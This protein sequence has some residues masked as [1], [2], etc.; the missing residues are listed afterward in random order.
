MDCLKTIYSRRGKLQWLSS[1]LPCTADVVPGNSGKLRFKVVFKQAS[2]TPNEWS[3]HSV[4]E[5]QE[6]ITRV[7][8]TIR[9][10]RGSYQYLSKLRPINI[11][12]T[13]GTSS[14]NEWIS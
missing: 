13:A 10:D 2:T 7:L 11:R 12:P 4:K 14:C 9:A 6:Q 1:C 3:V 5:G 8:R